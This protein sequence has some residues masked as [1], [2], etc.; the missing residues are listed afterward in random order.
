MKDDFGA[1]RGC[2]NLY[3]DNWSVSVRAED[4][5]ARGRLQEDALEFFLLVLRR[6]CSGLRLPVFVGSKHVGKEVGRQE[7]ATKLASVMEKWRKVWP[8]DTVRSA[9]NLLLMVA[10]D[11][12][13]SP[14]DWMCVSVRSVV[15][16]QP[17]GEAQRLVVGIYD[18][19]QRPS[20]AQ[21]VARNIDVLCGELLRPMVV[22]GPKWSFSEFQSVK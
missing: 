21:R 1:V 6:V 19:A 16:G 15:S 12:R 10:V 9:E 4:A 2:S 18:I 14:Q 22:T 11:E 8:G 5:L 3:M 7:N 13:P 20:L 17:L